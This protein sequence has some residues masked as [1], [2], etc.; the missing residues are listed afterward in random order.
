MREGAEVDAAADGLPNRSDLGL[1]ELHH[2]I[3]GRAT[4]IVGLL[5]G[6]AKKMDHANIGDR[7]RCERRRGNAVFQPLQ[8]RSHL[9]PRGAAPFAR[10]SVP[11]MAA[12]PKMPKETRGQETSHDRSPFAGTLQPGRPPLVDVP[13]ARPSSPAR[14]HRHASRS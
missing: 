2:L 3:D 6:G 14:P 4:V 13:S 8:L 12:H 9:S 7:H 5:D 11:R 1:I 10:R